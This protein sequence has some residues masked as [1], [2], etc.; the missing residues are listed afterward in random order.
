M[1]KISMILLMVGSS[2]SYNISYAASANECIVLDDGGLKNRCSS[3]TI[4]VR[5]CVPNSNSS[6][7]C[8]KGKTA[9]K[10]LGPG[11]RE[12]IPLY[13]SEGRGG[14]RKVA[15]FAPDLPAGWNG[16]GTYQC[17]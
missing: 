11:E 17:R 5:Y 3:K 16:S 12:F 4:N 13:K 6:H 15:C 9:M 14:I 7:S 1:K 8:S 2:L 10:T